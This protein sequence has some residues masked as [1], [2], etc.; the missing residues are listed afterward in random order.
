MS[1]WI[2]VVGS[3]DGLNRLRTQSDTWWCALKKAASGDLL[4]IYVARNR[5]RDLP[6]EEGGIVAIFQIVG[7]APERPAD[8]R[9]YRG[10]FGGPS[11]D[12]FAIVVKERFPV[13]LRLAEMKTDAHLGSA[14]FVRRSFEGTC[15]TA[16]S[17]QFQRIRELLKNKR[18]I[19]SK[20]KTG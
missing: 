12:P 15:F 7:P 20:K 5:L 6:E 17:E 10:A 2:G 14:S 1:Y 8:C 3:R 9:N 19:A 11:P 4:A 18:A 16:S 13:S